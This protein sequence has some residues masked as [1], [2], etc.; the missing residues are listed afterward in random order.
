MKRLLCFVLVAFSAAAF[1]QKKEAREQELKKKETSITP[2]KSLAG[3]VSRKKEKKDIAPTLT[4]DP[5]KIGLEGQVASK[6]GDQIAD[7]KKIIELNQNPAEMPDLLFRLGELYWEESKFHF[8]QANRKD[9]EK[10]QAMNRD[11]K[12]GIERAEKEKE[13]L[14]KESKDYAQQAIDQYAT[15]VQHYKKY[16]RTDEVLYFLGMNLI[17]MGDDKKALV[18]YKRLVDKYPKSKYWLDAQLAIGEYN[19]N[20]SKGKR[21][22][23]EKALEAYK[24]ATTDPSAKIYAYALYKMGWCFFNMADYESAMD[25]YKTVVMLG[26]VNGEADLEKD[27]AKKGAAP[28]Q[29][30]MKEARGDYVRAF[31]RGGGTPQEAKEKFAKLAKEPEDLR[32]MMKSLANLYYDD[33]KDKEAALAYDMLIKERPTSPEAPGFQSKIIDCVMRAGNKRMTVQQVRRLVKIMDEVVAKNP[34]LDDNGRITINEAKELAERTISNLAVN[35]HNEAKKTR[36]DEVFGLANEVYAD[37][38][39]L[40]PKNPKAYDLRF[41]WAE[42]L[43]DNL[44]K[45]REAAENYSKVFQKDITRL[46]KGEEQEDGTFKTPAKPGRY[47][48]NAAYNAILAWDQVVKNEAGKDAPPAADPNKKGTI[49]EAKKNLLEASERYLKYVDK[50]EKKV[51]I[52]YKIAKIYYDYNWLDEAVARFSEIALKYP[53]YKFENDRA[54]EICANLVLDSYNLLGDI[55]KVNEWARKFHAE[56]KLAVGKFRT[57]LEDIIEK[58][59]FKLVNQLE[60]RND[61]QK[62]AEAYVTFVNEFPKSE[63]AD[64]ALFNASIDFYKAKML[65]KA[66]EIRKTI[67]EKFPK[68]PNVP[69]CMFALAEGY[70]A[71][72]DYAK[73]ADYYETYVANFEKTKAGGGKKPAAKAAPKKGAKDDDKKKDPG[74]QVWEEAKAQDALF[75]AGIFREGLGQYQKA[76]RNREKYLELWPDSKDKEAVSKSIIDLYEK[77]GNWQKVA[78]E[79]EEYEKAWVKDPNKVLATEA[80]I[81][82]IYE[83]KMHNAK[84]AR[85]VLQRIADYYDKLSK[86]QKESLE[87]AALDG[88][89]RADFQD[90]EKDWAYYS[91]LKLKWSTL[92]NV[93]ELKASI[94]N[95]ATAL[96]EIQKKYTHTV[97]LK[98]ADPAIC[99]LHK[100]GLAYDQFATQLENPPVPKGIPEELLVEVKMQFVAQVNDL[101]LKEKATEAFE[102]AV[103]KSQELDVF[104]PCTVAALEQ[105][106]TKYKPERY[107]PMEEE[108]LEL[109]LDAQK[110]MSIGQDILTS[111]QPIPVISKEKAAEIQ[112]KAKE[113]TSAVADVRDDPPKD[114]DE[115]PPSPKKSKEPVIEDSPKPD[116]GAKPPPKKSQDVEPEEPL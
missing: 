64:K 70:E 76:L 16:P 15:I 87:V 24:A 4:Y 78:R 91:S 60:A 109:K 20:N 35:W 67:I 23:L 48:S 18:A 110:S 12:A 90:N 98:A 102:A 36:D 47:M 1:A 7:L 79:L 72:T 66:I 37:Y 30:L 94:K 99:A 58:T 93:G 96:T 21:D 56:P 73:A 41:F 59:S 100:I 45:Y 46:E 75:N 19:F 32:K 2:D 92:Q 71:T 77:M 26:M 5:F 39:A 63:L 89:G 31:A 97:T 55:A 86:K 115:P 6:R 17:E 51:E 108:V 85:G 104:N 43:N 68:S 40:F 65:D 81:A 33:G 112:Q 69:V 62:A 84:A 22:M 44:N 42:L 116:S 53:D 57:E 83:E 80:R 9:D 27:Q 105:L 106:R 95:K 52:T 11:D 14:I 82:T 107:P 114:L 49:P 103:Q 25:K 38:L 101:K 88:V 54:G 13:D 50:G 74:E 113:T 8:F 34:K 61:F 10:I 3:D 111:I 29:S 28:K